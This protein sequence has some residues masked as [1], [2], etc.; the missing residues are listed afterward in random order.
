MDPLEKFQSW[1][2]HPIGKHSVYVLLN[3]SHMLKLWRN[4]FGCKTLY[5][6]EGGVIIFKYIEDLCKFQQ[7]EEFLA[8][9]KI[10]KKHIQ[11]HKEKMKV[12]LAVQTL[13]TSVA[14]AL[15][16]LNYDLQIPIFKGSETTVKFIRMADRLF[17]VF[18]S[19]NIFGSAPFKAPLSP[20]N[21]ADIKGLG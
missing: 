19:K 4:T 13:S 3:P 16:F 20:K 2:T 6:S 15:D 7:N 18:N 8:G 1:F 10:R 17:D 14:D 9:N 11:F 21:I 5:D 12:S